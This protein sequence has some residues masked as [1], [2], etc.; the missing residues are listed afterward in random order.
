MN[1]PRYIQIARQRAALKSNIK[2]LKADLKTA[3][4]SF[5]AMRL[6]IT[7]KRPEWQAVLAQVKQARKDAG[8]LVRQAERAL[9]KEQARQTR[10]VNQ[11]LMKE[12]RNVEAALNNSLFNCTVN[13]SAMNRAVR[14]LDPQWLERAKA[15]VA[16]EGNLCE[17]ENNLNKARF[18]YNLVRRQTERDILTPNRPRYDARQDILD[19]ETQLR[20]AEKKDA[21]LDRQMYLLT[22]EK[23]PTVQATAIPKND[24]DVVQRSY[25]S[26]MAATLDQV[27]AALQP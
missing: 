22:Q 2:K 17:L 11:I 23:K 12:L 26:E 27:R 18:Q 7:P 19:L 24:V 1:D 16:S 10:L 4:W 6:R 5:R 14:V 15:E 8:D 21:D 3:K 9:A 13:H 25:L 20:Q